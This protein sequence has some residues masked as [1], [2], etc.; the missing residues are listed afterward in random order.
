[1]SE[2]SKGARWPTAKRGTCG[3][4]AHQ[5]ITG[6]VQRLH[7]ELF[8]A[9]QRDKP[10]RRSRCRLRNPFRISGTEFHIQGTSMIRF[11]GPLLA[12]ALVLGSVHALA[13]AGATPP[14]EEHNESTSRQPPT[15]DDVCR[16]LEEAA[17]EN[18]LPVEFFAR[19]I[20]QESRFNARALS[21]R[22][23]CGTDN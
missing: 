7:V 5:S 9:L 3:P 11:A 21:P 16:T 14:R 6:P 12:W 19:V 23:G 8:L 17:A 10:H 15:A 2:D 22:V 18:G 20:W 13:Q 1:M 4:F